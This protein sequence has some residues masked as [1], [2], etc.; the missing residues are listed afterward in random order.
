MN[1]WIW[2]DVVKAVQKCFRGIRSRCCVLLLPP[3]EFTSALVL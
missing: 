1:L 2:W 3:N